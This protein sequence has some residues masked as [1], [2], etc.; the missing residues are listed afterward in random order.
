VVGQEYHDPLSGIDF[1]W[2]P[3]GCFQMGPTETEKQYLT[4]VYDE[5]T[6]KQYL[7]PELPQ[8]EVCLDGFWMGKTEVTQ[9]QWQ[10]VMGSNPSRFEGDSRPVETVSWND[11]QEFL[12]KLD[13][14]AAQEIY[15]LPTEAEWEYAARA[16]TTTMFSFG[17]NVDALGDYAWQTDNSEYTTHAAGQLQPNN[18]GLYD[19]HGNV[20]EWCGDWYYDAYYAKSPLENPQ[21]PESG[22]SRVMRGGAWSQKPYACRSALRSALNPEYGIDD[23]GFRVVVDGSTWIQ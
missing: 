10:Q 18:W 9:A 5:E 1:V 23:L 2:I 12:K 20:W 3:E 7:E 17:D 19:M 21:G 22:E 8:H 16:G 15:R 4:Q 11:A 6:Y 13:T 14:Q